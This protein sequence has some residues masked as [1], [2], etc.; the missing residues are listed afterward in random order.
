VRIGELSARSG[1][2][3]RMLR[4]YEEKGLLSPARGAN[5]YREYDDRDVTRAGLVSSM[6]RSGLPTKLIIP[7][8]QQWCGARDVDGPDEDVV[9]LLD[10]EAARLDSRIACMSLSRR[11]IQEY[12]DRFAPVSSGTRPSAASRS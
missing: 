12:L 3:V 6:I 7:L 10:A 2:P 8:L 11:A 4:Y 9:A 1:V 5:G